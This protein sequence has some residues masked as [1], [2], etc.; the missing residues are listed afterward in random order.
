MSDRNRVGWFLRP[1]GAQ[2]FVH[3]VPTAGAVGYGLAPL[4]G[5]GA[6][7]AVMIIV[8][9]ATADARAETPSVTRSVPSAVAPGK[10]VEVT[11]SGS[12]LDA[13][14]ALWTSVPATATFTAGSG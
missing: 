11:L 12:G 3:A 10:T 2:Y 8:L 9:V 4:R 14:T 6:L 1:S 7:T 13:P 5:W